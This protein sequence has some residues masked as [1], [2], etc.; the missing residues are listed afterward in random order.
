MATIMVRSYRAG[1]LTHALAPSSH[2]PRVPPSGIRDAAS[3]HSCEGS[4]GSGPYWVVP[5]VFPINPAGLACLE[6]DN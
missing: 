1:L 6:P 5:T 4:Y 3:V 2:L